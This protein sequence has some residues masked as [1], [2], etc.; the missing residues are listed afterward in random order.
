MKASEELLELFEKGITEEE[1]VHCDSMMQIAAELEE[2]IDT[3]QHVR[4]MVGRVGIS[5][6]AFALEA[7]SYHLICAYT[8]MHQIYTDPRFKYRLKGIVAIAKGK[9]HEMEKGDAT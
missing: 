2:L 7:V 9:A 1:I 6:I 3:N 4:L 5:N 8:G